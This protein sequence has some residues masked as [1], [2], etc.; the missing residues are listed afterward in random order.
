MSS[1]ATIRTIQPEGWKRPK[2]YANGVAFKGETLQIAGQ[3]GWDANEN[4]VG[5][6]MASQF[7][8][9]L[10]NVIAVV[11]AAGGEPTNIVSMTVFV[12]DV[13]AYR[14]STSAIGE[15]WR[16]KLGKHFPAM[17]LIGVKELLE[18]G[19]IVEICAVAALLRTTKA[20]GRQ[21]CCDADPALG[22]FTRADKRAARI[23]VAGQR[24]GARLIRTSNRPAHQR[25][26]VRIARAVLCT[27]LTCHGQ[28]HAHARGRVTNRPCICTLRKRKR[29]GER[30]TSLTCVGQPFEHRR[31]FASYRARFGR[32]D[33]TNAA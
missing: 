15:A 21:Q 10:D 32:T 1:N 5:P 24:R 19:A 2:G 6:D 22:R 16:N 13:D 31:A 3:I 9:A 30:T 12:T 14:A 18:P 8:Q 17:A 33:V 28:L 4:I 11:R 23:R 25:V 26:T 20:R 7:A 27:R 29:S